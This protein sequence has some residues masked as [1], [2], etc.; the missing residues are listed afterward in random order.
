MIV[1]VDYGIG[2]VGSVQNMLR[3]VGRTDVAVSHDPEVIVQAEKLILPGVGAFDRG[4]EQI[5]GAPH[6]REA[7]DEVA[8]RK[9]RPVLGVCLG[10]QLLG[11]GSE[12][13][14]RA[15]LGWI[16]SRCM[17]MRSVLPEGLRIPH[18]GWNQVFP[19]RSHP[20]LGR[21]PE[22]PR[23][24]FVHSYFMKCE[25]PEDVLLECDYG[26]RFTCGVQRDNIMGVQFHPEKSHK[27]G[28]AL[29]TSFA[30]M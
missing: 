18:M 1:I 11:R 24:Y 27:Y 28:L 23:F 20:L 3:R 14:T 29:L 10:M 4:M 17:G 6:L 9:R 13:G 2:N 22:K 5:E 30:E 7:L 26:V 19:A 16:D 12:E 25:D 8:L 15:G 21:L